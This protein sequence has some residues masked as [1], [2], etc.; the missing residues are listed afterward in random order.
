M[1]DSGSCMCYFLYFLHNFYAVDLLKDDS[2][3]DNTFVDI[4]GF[5]ELVAEL[6]G[7]GVDVDNPDEYDICFLIES[8]E[9]STIASEFSCA[10]NIIPDGDIDEALMSDS[11]GAQSCTPNGSYILPN[12]VIVLADQDV[13]AYMNGTLVSI[14][15]L[16]E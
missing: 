1:F 3:S 6:E 13:E 15:G 7:A 10:S 11:V 12:G 9:D 4:K 2:D 16:T 8:T 5:V 14:S